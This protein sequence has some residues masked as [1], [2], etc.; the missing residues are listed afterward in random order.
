LHSFGLKRARSYEKYDKKG[1]KVTR[2]SPA[3]VES[4]NKPISKL[5][6]ELRKHTEARKKAEREI[7]D[8]F[9]FPH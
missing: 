1:K 4:E 7:L 3:K 6:D 9:C 5:H 8:N 2:I